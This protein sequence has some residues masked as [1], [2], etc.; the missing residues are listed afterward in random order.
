MIPRW[1]HGSRRCCAPTRKARASW[2]IPLLSHLQP[3]S[4]RSLS[5]DL[6]SSRGGNRAVQAAGADRRRGLR[7][8]LHGRADSEPVRRK[9]ALKVIKPGMDTRAGDRP[10]RGRAAGAGAD[11]P[12][13]H[14]QGARRRRDGHRPAVLRDGAGPRRADH[15]V[16]RPAPARRRASG[17]SCS[18]P[19]ARRCSTPIRKGSSTATSSR[20]NVLVTLHDG[21]PVVKV[22]D[23]G[24]AK[25]IGP[26]AHREDAVHRLRAD[27]RHAAVHEPRAGRA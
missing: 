10:L 14:R 3:V 1:Q 25:A 13:E 6:R 26:A 12:P 16:L 8:R 7:R 20:S 18:S 19:S 4:R 9:V 24:V 5:A 11:G 15:R 17:W 2:S 27:D 23:F 22:I 21:R